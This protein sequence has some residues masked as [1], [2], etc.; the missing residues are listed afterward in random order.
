[1][2]VEAAPVPLRVVLSLSALRNFGTSVVVLGPSICKHLVLRIWFGWCLS[3]S[4]RDWGTF[5]TS[6]VFL[7]SPP[8]LS[9]WFCGSGL[10]GVCLSPRLGDL[11]DVGCLSF[12]PSI[13]KHLVL[14]IWFGSSR[15][16]R[17]GPDVGASSSS[18]SCF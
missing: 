6:V 13:S 15:S 12:E 16:R 4:L 7:L 1:M 9:T 17:L 3:L 2:C 18:N 14:R 11:Q 10:G 5:R 8:F